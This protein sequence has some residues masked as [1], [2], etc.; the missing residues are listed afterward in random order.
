M[1]FKFL[2]VS[3][4]TPARTM[5]PP[6]V[7]FP[8][9]VRAIALLGILGAALAVGASLNAQSILGSTASYGVMAGSTVTIN[10]ATAITGDLG[11]ANIGGSGP[12]SLTGA[13]VIPITAGNLTDFSRAFDGLAAMAPTEN[14]STLTLG[15][16]AGATIL[17]PGIYKFNDV[18]ALT[19]TLTLDALGQSNA[20]WVFQI[21]TT[22]D[23]TANA[24]VVFTHTVGDSVANYGL[25]WQIGTAATIGAGTTLEGNFLGGTTYTF[26]TGAT[27]LHGRA[28]AGATG[29][30]GLASNTINFIAADS[31]YSGGLAF[32][33][34]GS[35]ISAVPEPTTYALLAGVMA[36]AAVIV[37]RRLR[38]RLTIRGETA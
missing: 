24:Q 14:L 17:P 35:A 30:I 2:T 3:S 36:L 11:A 9:S 37:G 15:T 6:A 4:A 32:S 31:G 7:A 38:P 8:G 5:L 22:F 19:G 12:S 16:S 1:K 26:D 10:G 33:G 27:I 21:G 18:A 13:Q 34:S 29:T 20:V 28:L 25:F 23:T